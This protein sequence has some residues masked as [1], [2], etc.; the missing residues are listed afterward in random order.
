MG[1]AIDLTGKRFGKLVVLNK[2]ATPPHK[3]G[4]H[5]QVA[6]DCGVEF[7]SNTSEFNSGRRRGCP[8]KCGSKLIDLTG[9]RF[10]KLL[11]EGRANEV[12]LKPR[13]NVVC[14]CGNKEVVS[15][16]ALIRR[17]MNQCIRCYGGT[18][19]WNSLIDL[20]G[21]RFTR[22]LVIDRAPNIGKNVAWNC[23]CDC[24]KQLVVK[25]I[26]LTLGDTKSCG[27][28]SRDRTTERNTTHGLSRTPEYK[29]LAGAIQRCHNPG[30]P[31]YEW[32]GAKGIKVCKRWRRE[33]GSP[34]I[35]NF[36]SDMPPKPSPYHT[37]ER[38]KNE[39]DYCPENCYWLL[40]GDQSRTSSN[41][42]LNGHVNEIRERFASWDGTD[43]DFAKSVC[44]EYGVLYL[45]ILN[46]IRGK[47][48][49]DGDVLRPD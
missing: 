17:G 23:E 49:P 6:C 1:K 30:T 19:K 48:Y 4:V 14:D 8:N 13:W 31:A 18:R 12:G 37:L 41:A 38:E 28:L 5:W 33:D 3:R 34:N 15:S 45:T 9:K 11:V 43:I 2:V 29:T 21:Q 16:S 39:G 42:K 25:G 46:C 40:S 22:L 47:T 10:G 27:C 35:E 26:Y 24:G 20:T 32:Y 44:E 7:V 36:V